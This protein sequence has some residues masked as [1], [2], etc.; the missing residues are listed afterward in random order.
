MT[1]TKEKIESLDYR[2]KSINEQISDL[3]QTKINLMMIKRE[4]HFDDT[5][6][7]LETAFDN[8]PEETKKDMYKNFEDFS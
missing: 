3:E 8:L 1:S 6:K 7:V 2:I 4:I 5:K